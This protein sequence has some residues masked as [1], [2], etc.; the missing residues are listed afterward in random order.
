MR[1]CV[2]MCYQSFIVVQ[3]DNDERE[4]VVVLQNVFTHTL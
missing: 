1:V 4:P 2:V 3:L